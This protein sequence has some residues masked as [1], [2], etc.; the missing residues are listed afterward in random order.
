MA[1]RW[2]IALDGLLKKAVKHTGGN[3]I[4]RGSDDP[5]DVVEDFPQILFFFR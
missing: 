3:R 4:L 1:H 2:G 5:L